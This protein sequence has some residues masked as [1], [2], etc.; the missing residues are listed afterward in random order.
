MKKVVFAIALVLGALSINSCTDN[1]L[2]ELENERKY[3]KAI[4]IAERL[5]IMGCSNRDTLPYFNASDHLASL[6]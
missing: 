2:E 4:K 1:S 6:K 3:Q 5:T